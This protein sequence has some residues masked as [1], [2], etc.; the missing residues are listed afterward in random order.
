MTVGNLHKTVESHS[1]QL[2]GAFDRRN[3]EIPL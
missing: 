2:T 3:Y 1:V